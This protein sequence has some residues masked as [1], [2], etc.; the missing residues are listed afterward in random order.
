MYNMSQSG[1]VPIDSKAVWE[2]G[3]E[4]SSR[5]AQQEHMRLEIG[6]P[7][8]EMKAEECHWAPRISLLL[9]PVWGTK[10]IYSL[11][12]PLVVYTGIPKT[13]DRSLP[14]EGTAMEP[15]QM[16]VYISSRV[17]LQLCSKQATS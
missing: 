9:S 14:W 1:N 5:S 13:L 11:C 4:T 6:T 17:T 3:H 15:R 7:H 2:A 12:C 10:C 8:L 16:T